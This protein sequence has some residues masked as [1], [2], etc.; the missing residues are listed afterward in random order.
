MGC[1]LIKTF[2]LSIDVTEQIQKKYLLEFIRHNIENNLYNLNADTT[3]IKNNIYFYFIYCDFSKT[4][5]ILVFDYTSQILPNDFLPKVYYDIQN[6]QDNTTDIFVFDN[7]FVI[8]K[9]KKLLFSKTTKQSTVEEMQLFIK[10]KYN[11]NITN[12]YDTS[13]LKLDIDKINNSIKSHKIYP[14]NKKINKRFIVYA[15]LSI[16]MIILYFLNINDIL[17]LNNNKNTKYKNQQTNKDIKYKHIQSIYDTKT[18]VVS[19][20]IKFF[21]YL[22]LNKINI[23]KI[24]YKDNKLYT[25]LTHNIKKKLLDTV[26]ISQQKIN[27]INIIK[28]NDVYNM[29]VYIDIERKKQ[30]KTYE[31]L[32]KIVLKANSFTLINIIEDKAVSFNIDITT[33]KNDNGSLYLE[34]KTTYNNTM[35]FLL[36]LEQRLNINKLEVKKNKQIFTTTIQLDTKYLFHKNYKYNYIQNIVN[37]FVKYHKTAKKI[38]IKK[39]INKPKLILMAILDQST[40]ING[41]WYKIN[42]SIYNYKIK[43]IKKDYIILYNIKDN[44]E[45]KLTLS[46][47][48]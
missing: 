12:I 38:N 16:L 9:D 6:S 32:Q 29:D 1:K 35:N 28:K 43:K 8:Y 46:S 3:I 41:K 25:T 33:I 23:V 37:A 26:T 17:T 13:A 31:E 48:N 30:Q 36:F 10:Q 19:T 47:T 39:H 20:T 2:T 5:E 34:F 24:D 21:R 4:Y 14:L 40:L 7:Y 18:I 22:K 42:D 45:I 27:I 44:H 11:L 15:T